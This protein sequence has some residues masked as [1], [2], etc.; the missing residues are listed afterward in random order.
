MCSQHGVDVMFAPSVQEMYP[1]SPT[2]RIEVDALG[3]NLC[4]ASR[5]GHF[6]AVAIV[7]L[8]L[9]N[10]AGKSHQWVEN[11]PLNRV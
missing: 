4:G 10:L 2:I 11:E 6:L 7:V 9:L 5:P 8:K 3:S 1:R